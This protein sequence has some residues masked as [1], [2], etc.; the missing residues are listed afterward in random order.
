[1]KIKFLLLSLLFIAVLHANAQTKRALVVA[2]GKYDFNKTK[3]RPINVDNDVLLIQEALRKQN[4]RDEN[5]ILLKD[6]AATRDAIGKAM[7][8]LA[9]NSGPGDVVV[10]HFST[11]GQQLEDDGSDEMDK[12]DEAIVPYDAVYNSNPVEFQ[13]YAPGYFRDDLF[14][15]KITA[16]RNSLGSKGDLLV[17]LDACHSG[18]G[19]RGPGT[20]VV[21]GANKPMVS[22]KFDLK[23]EGTKDEAGVFKESTKVKLNADAA[24]YVVLSGA[25]AQELNWET[26]DENRKP[27]GSLSYAFSKAMSTLEGPT[28]YRTLFASIENIMR[29]KSPKQKPVLEGDG[30][31]RELFGGNY[32]K[33]KAYFTIIAAQSNNAAIEIN[34]GT[35]SGLTQ[36]SVVSF[37]PS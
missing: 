28:S 32:V 14:G 4:F 18:T 1:M 35:V 27:V 21:R 31:D 25:Q 6:A 17:L 8:K 26:I 5:M 20:A 22:N 33:Q 11:H 19:T 9:K 7:D 16:I 12:L 23:K 37:Y 3:W 34:A 24:T 29:E 36:G 10:I 15:E 2:I 13:K 30:T